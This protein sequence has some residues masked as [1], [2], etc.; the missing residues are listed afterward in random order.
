MADILVLNAESIK[1]INLPKDQPD[2]YTLA[3]AV[4]QGQLCAI[5]VNGKGILAN[6][7]AAGTAQV[8]MLGLQV[9]GIGET[10]SGLERGGVFGYDLTSVPYDTPLYVSDT[11]GALSDTPGTVTVKCGIVKSR[12]S[13]DLEKYVYFDIDLRGDQ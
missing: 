9:G 3:S 2:F 8:R 5:D 4:T 13:D 1:R 11:P 12:S 6:A 10:I 7:S